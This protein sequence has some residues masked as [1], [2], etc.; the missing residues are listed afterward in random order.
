MQLPVDGFTPVVHAVAVDATDSLVG[1]TTYRL[2]IEVPDTARN[3]YAVYGDTANPLTLPPA[4]TSAA[5]VSQVGGPNS[6]LFSSFPELEFT[7]YITVGLTEGGSDLATDS[8]MEADLEAWTDEVGLSCSDGA[9][10]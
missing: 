6:V 9:V 8:V 2:S 10:F 1:F 3:L 7:S 5:S 4:W